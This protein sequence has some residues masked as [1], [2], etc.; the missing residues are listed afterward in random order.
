[1][2]SWAVIVAEKIS[3]RLNGDMANRGGQMSTTV[4]SANKRTIRSWPRFLTSSRAQSFFGML[5]VILVIFIFPAGFAM[6]LYYLFVLNDD[7][8]KAP[9]ALFSTWASFGISVAALIIGLI[10]YFTLM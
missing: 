4:N 7:N 9:I 10:L 1:M 2:A 5:S 6:S 3:N 8:E